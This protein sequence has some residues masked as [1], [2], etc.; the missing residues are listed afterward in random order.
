MLYNQKNPHGGDIYGREIRLD[1]SANTNPFGTPEGICDAI[2]EAVPQLHRY[3]DPY[4]R[5]LVSAI[6]AHEGVDPEFILC[7]NGAAELIFSW[8]EAV[9]AASALEPAPTFSEY[10][11]AFARLGGEMHFYPLRP[12]NGF[13]PGPDLTE[14]I[15]RERPQA[16]FLCNPNNPTGQL[17][18]PA[19]LEEAVELTGKLGI[20]LFLDECFLDLTDG[21][22]SLIPRLAEH[23]HL[24]I[25]KAFTK[26]Y[27][28]AGVR[29]G[30]VLSADR[31][32]LEAMSA[33]VQPW[34]VSTVAQRAGVAALRED[35]FLEHTR[36]LIRQERPVLKQGLEALGLKVFPSDV[37]FLLFS[38]PVGL[39]EALLREKIA[40]RSCGNY[41]GL[42]EG[43]Y[44]IA[45][46]LPEQNRQLLEAMK[47]A[48]EDST[49]QKTS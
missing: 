44:R 3:P 20:R 28:M 36:A 19:L 7:G 40:I 42:S 32:L 21:G 6:S 12:E 22:Q 27:G 18:P 38:G 35:A 45:V 33:T 17:L 24:T 29:L 8:C 48:M 2:R 47:R 11:R 5:S 49:W 31:A 14:Q 41:P 26:S 10:G 13:R 46:R 1:Y 34:N 43:W 15:A 4:C 37:N 23:P 30:Y 25:L 9:R 16:V 39:D